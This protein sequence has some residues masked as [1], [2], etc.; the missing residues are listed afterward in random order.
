MLSFDGYSFCKAHSAS[1]A[2]VSY[3]LA[4]MKAHYPAI[5]MAS[6]INNGGGFYGTQAYV[7]EARRLG[8]EILPPH[9]NASGPE[10]RVESVADMKRSEASRSSDRAAPHSTAKRSEWGSRSCESSRG[11]PSTALVAAREALRA[12]G[13]G[14][15]RQPGRVRGPASRSKQSELRALVR[16]GCLDG[17]P[18]ALRAVRR[19]GRPQALWA[20]HRL[21]ERSRRGPD[22]ALGPELIEDSWEPPAWIRDYAASTR[23]ADEARLLGLVLSCVPAALFAGRAA[24]V[25]RRRGLPPP[26]PSFCLAGGGEGR[27]LC[28]AGTAVAGKEVVAKD[29]RS[30]AFYTFEDEAGLFETVFFPQ[31]YAKALPTLEGNRAVLMVGTARREYGA[32]PSMSRRPSASTA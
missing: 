3:R 13:G 12:Q 1:Y 30:M 32:S 2:L 4:W 28:L 20:L 19:S 23:L 9:V 24:L 29:G 10:Y 11:R 21:R 26:S 5:F 6:V 7:G 14:G 25:A 16:S 15:L 8:I 17:L 31:A 27:R 22:P 18:R